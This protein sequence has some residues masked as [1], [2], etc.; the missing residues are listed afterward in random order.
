ML[1]CKLALSSAR[2]LSTTS[3]GYKNI[4]KEVVQKKKQFRFVT[5]KNFDLRKKKKKTPLNFV[6]YTII[7]I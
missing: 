2:T 7:A 3:G 4:T 1:Q 6:L 5:I